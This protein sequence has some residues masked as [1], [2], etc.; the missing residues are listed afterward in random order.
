MQSLEDVKSKDFNMILD[1]FADCVFAEIWAFLRTLPEKESQQ[2]R[3]CAN[4]FKEDIW[5]MRDIE[6]HARISEQKRKCCN[7]F[8]LKKSER[9]K[10]FSDAESECLIKAEPIKAKPLIKTVSC[11]TDNIEVINLDVPDT[12]RWPK[13]PVKQ[14]SDA[15]KSSHVPP[16]Q[17]NNTVEDS[18][19]SICED[20]SYNNCLDN[21]EIKSYFEDFVNT[22]VTRITNKDTKVNDH[23]SENDTDASD[24][25]ALPEQ[26]I[27]QQKPPYPTYE[28]VKH[29]L[30]TRSQA[31][32]D[33]ILE[34]I[35]EKSEARLKAC[36][37]DIHY[38]GDESDISDSVFDSDKELDEN[39]DNRPENIDVSLYEEAKTN[40]DIYNQYAMLN[41]DEVDSKVTIRKNEK[42][43]IPQVIP[44][45][46]KR[47]TGD[48]KS[49]PPSLSTVSEI[50]ETEELKTD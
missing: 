28:Q 27:V 48:Y 16:T 8:R 43:T 37:L 36:G 26:L 30:P 10:I 35:I 1:L 3:T 4:T 34:D 19:C 24:D 21:E 42:K 47:E 45:C 2:L 23:C 5:S 31:E 6:K 40:P 12:Q 38:S 11:Q 32:T 39:F 41:I 50:N 22:L 33:A 13:L 15:V 29:L 17:L 14:Y 49:A 44:R 7:F 18:E 9:E 46:L 20:P 25:K